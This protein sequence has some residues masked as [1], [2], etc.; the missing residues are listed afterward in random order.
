MTSMLEKPQSNRA[1]SFR[2][3]DHGS[4]AERQG[5][6]KKDSIVWEK[7][8]FYVERARNHMEKADK[9]YL[10]ELIR[11]ALEDESPAER[12]YE[13]SQR[14][15]KEHSDRVV[16]EYQVIARLNGHGGYEEAALQKELDDLYARAKE[17][18]KELNELPRD[19]KQTEGL[20]T[21]AELDSRVDELEGELEV[22]K[23]RIDDFEGNEIAP[24]MATYDQKT[25]K[26]IEKI[27]ARTVMQDGSLSDDDFGDYSGD[28]HIRISNR[29]R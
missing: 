10:N 5:R 22:V 18:V 13:A 17:I 25:K 14:K 6:I 21:Q 16:S 27:T 12:D 29:P 15:S 7:D 8:P 4:A 3:Q 23:W 2:K 26:E 24:T 1:K 20:W 9:A 11:S 28:S 19:A